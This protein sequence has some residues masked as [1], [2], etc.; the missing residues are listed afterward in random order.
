MHWASYPVEESNWSPMHA[1]RQ[2]YTRIIFS[3]NVGV[4]CVYLDEDG[5]V[6]R[7]W[8]EYDK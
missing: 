5:S 2:K 1:P 8:V 7:Q 4:Q 6:V 3:R